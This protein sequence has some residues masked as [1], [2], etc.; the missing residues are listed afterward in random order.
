MNRT[1]TIQEVQRSMRLK[2]IFRVSVMSAIIYAAAIIYF[3][4]ILYMFLSGFKSEFQAVRPSF[5]FKPTLET[6]GKVLSDPNMY[7]YLRNSF[8]QVFAGTLISLVLGMPAAFVLVF[9]KFRKRESNEKIYMW[10]ITT[11][12][13]PP[14]AVL[15]PLYTWYQ[16]FNLNRT[17]L[18][19][20][21]AY[22][23]FHV[24]I[25]VWMLYSFVSDIPVEIMEASEIDGCTRM[26]QLLFMAVPLART[27][28]IASGLLV[29]VFIWNEFFLGFNLTSNVT[30]TLPVYMARFREQ[31]GMFIAQLSASSTIA[32]LPAVVLGWMTQKSL[33]KGLTMGAVKG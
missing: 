23:G 12:L 5:V 11:I 15:I 19:L 33:V 27:G 22:I 6:Y 3:F 26:Q 30:A 7:G 28:I 29:A 20:L 2:K 1:R 10:F 24:P 13:L 31:Q 8:F 14:V 9:G 21:I 4:P 17:P 18:G 16:T 25:V 32:I